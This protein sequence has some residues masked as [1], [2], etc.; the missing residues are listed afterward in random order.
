M[1][2]QPRQNQNQAIPQLHE[3]SGLGVGA[4]GGGDVVEA[5]GREP[6]GEPGDD[7]ADDSL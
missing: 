7:L 3:I 6:L 4:D 2:K 5:I 1:P